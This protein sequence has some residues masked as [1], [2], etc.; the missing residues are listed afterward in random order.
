MGGPDAPCR[1]EGGGQ[2][3][4]PLN[5]SMNERLTIERERRGNPKLETTKHNENNFL[6][7]TEKS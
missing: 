2:G 7:Q 3:H 1:R 5:E 4:R 6:S